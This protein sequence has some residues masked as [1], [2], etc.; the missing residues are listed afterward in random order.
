MRVACVRG[1]HRQLLV[2][3]AY[4]L[5]YVPRDINAIQSLWAKRTGRRRLECARLMF[6]GHLPVLKVGDKCYSEHIAI[7]RFIARQVP[8]RLGVPR[9][10][11]R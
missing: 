2:Y 10:V 4:S 6:A 11:S 5:R 8:P 3:A 1:S 9:L 7:C